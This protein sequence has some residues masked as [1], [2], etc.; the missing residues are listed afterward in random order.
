MST[1]VVFVFGKTWFVENKEH[2]T[3]CGIYIYLSFVI[4]RDNT[5]VKYIINDDRFKGCL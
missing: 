3:S 1:V 2:C 5:M 4:I